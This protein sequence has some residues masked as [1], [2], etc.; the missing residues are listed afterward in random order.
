M[1][2]LTSLLLVCV[3]GVF[4]YGSA[5]CYGEIKSNKYHKLPWE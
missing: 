5:H 3:A 2:F 4:A 1:E